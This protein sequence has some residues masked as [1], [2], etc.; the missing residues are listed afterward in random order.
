MKYKWTIISLLASFFI[1]LPIWIFMMY[2]IL[3]TIK[4]DDLTWFLF[5]VY[6]PLVFIVT[7]LLKISE[8][9]TKELK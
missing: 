5:W 7:I 1:Y 8:V 3:K 4:A 2:R 6:I 9:E